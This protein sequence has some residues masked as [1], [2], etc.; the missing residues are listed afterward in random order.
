VRSFTLVALIAVPAFAQTVY[1]WEDADGT[2]YT[3]DLS[4]VP[5]EKQK[6][7]E[8]QRLEAH[9]ATGL[10]A[11]APAPVTLAL[12]PA[13]TPSPGEG[14]GP[15]ANEAEWRGRFI[16]AHR[17][18]ESTRASLSALQ[19]SL[20]PRTECIQQPLTTVTATGVVT[21]T[22]RFAQ[23]CQINP[24]YDQLRV[25]IGQQGV[26][27]KNAEAD[28]EQL[29]RWASMYAIPREWRRGW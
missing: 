22:G 6:K 28:L 3:D 21:P 25:Q 17:R 14:P 27:L 11:G 10:S 20:P 16:D 1:S 8:T 23:R 18:V 15:S 2:H 4:Q 9:H 19:A 13:Q 24:L 26:E 29:E 12:A 5:K 7:V